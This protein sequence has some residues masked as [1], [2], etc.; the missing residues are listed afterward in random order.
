MF[1]IL[2]QLTSIN[3]KWLF[4]KNVVEVIDYSLKCK[5]ISSSVGGDS[6]SYL[7]FVS[8]FVCNDEFLLL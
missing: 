2:D 1:V 7:C 3:L 6:Y 4:S 5:L 8:L